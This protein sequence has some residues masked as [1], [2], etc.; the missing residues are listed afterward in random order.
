L[1]IRGYRLEQFAALGFEGAAERLLGPGL[2]LGAG[3]AR[4]YE[5]LREFLD[6]L[7]D[8]PAVEALRLGLAALPTHLQP[9]DLIGAFPVIL[10][11]SRHGS[12]L[13]A[14]NSQQGHVKDLL[15]LYFGQQPEPGAVEG[16]SCY[17]AT[18]AEHGMNAS[19]FTARVIASTGAPML[20]ALLGALGALKGPLHGGAPGPVLDLLDEMVG[21]SDIAGDLRRKIA[22][23]ERLMGFGHRI[24][25]T[26]D[27][28]ADVL[29]R[30]VANLSGSPRLQ[31]AQ[32]VESLAQQALR[33]AKPGRRLDTNV[34]FYTAVLLERLGFPRG[35]FTSLFAT[36]RV[37]GWIAHYREQRV[38]GRLIRPN[39]VYIGPRPEAQE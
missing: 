22:A 20:D 32:Q 31:L 27:P 36:G 1:V 30:A 11:A 33:E 10:G 7:R 34:E 12:D 25:R 4:A 15:T 35:D 29:K 21:S 19:T 24:Y 37:L 38:T 13:L 39:S 28:R 14:P 17:L 9:Q 16:L 18:V 3:R 5:L 8:R 6:C 23:G 2:D 26:R